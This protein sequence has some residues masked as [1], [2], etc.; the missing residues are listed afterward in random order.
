[1]RR[2]ILA[3]TLATAFT[4][5]PAFADHLK[6]GVKP[7]GFDPDYV[8]CLL[9]A[10]QATDNLRFSLEATC[11]QEITRLC[12]WGLDGIEAIRLGQCLL[13]EAEQVR[14]YLETAITLFPAEPPQGTD[15]FTQRRL[16]RL[17][18]EI[19][20]FGEPPAAEDPMA[21]IGRFTGLTLTLKEIIA[22]A[23]RFEVTL[24]PG[25]VAAPDAHSLGDL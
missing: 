10:A 7:E 2:E 12:E 5:M 8:G 13:F 6:P 16:T 24:P 25:P 15:Q 22:L 20:T 1:M 19:A 9:A 11:T 18:T 21:A 3:A 17:R 23:A 14:A 4:A